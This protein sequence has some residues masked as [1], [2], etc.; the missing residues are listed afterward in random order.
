ME[1]IAIDVGGV[2][3]EK[4]NKNGF[5]TNFDINDVKWLPGALD[6][7]KELSQYYDLYVLSFCGKKTENETRQALRKE[8]L[9]IIPEWKWIFTREREH[10]IDRMKQNG[11]TTL[12][13]DTERIIEWVNK[14]GLKGIHYGSK[15]TP[16]WN[17][18]VK[19]LLNGTQNFN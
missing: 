4:K 7:I 17:E 1:K 2:L 14:A 11:I 5:D 13:D 8:V 19:Q 15:N 12:I 3:I 10:K 16:N 9:P 6:A 18:V